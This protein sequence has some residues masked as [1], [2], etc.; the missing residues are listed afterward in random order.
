MVLM[1]STA[2]TIDAGLQ[3]DFWLQKNVNPQEEIMLVN[4]FIPTYLILQIH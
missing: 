2:Y 1:N 3:P 4:A